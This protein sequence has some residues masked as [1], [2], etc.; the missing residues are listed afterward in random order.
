MTMM[1]KEVIAGVAVVV[2]LGIAVFVLRHR[3]KHLKVLYYQTKWAELQ[4]L[5]GSKATWSEAI[6]NADKLLDDAL[7]KKRFG[8]KSPG[9][10]LVAAQRKF[11]D[12]DS[13]WFAHKLRDKIKVE[14]KIKLRERDVKNAL[15]GVR[16][17]L[18]D[19]GALP[20]GKS[21]DK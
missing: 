12:N 21:K 2:V 9:E 19:I 10:R 13:I 5:C 1:T 7:K 20:D 14:P 18:K 6:I 3:P 11:T 4:K 17:A 16:Q 15:L 8:G